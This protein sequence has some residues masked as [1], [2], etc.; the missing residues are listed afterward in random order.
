MLKQNEEKK[1]TL[2]ILK[3]LK[4]EIERHLKLKKT[5][6]LLWIRSVFVKKIKTKSNIGGCG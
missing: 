1:V 2:D 5:K 3:Q 6:E 4:D